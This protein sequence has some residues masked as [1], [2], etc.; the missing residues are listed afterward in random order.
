MKLAPSAFSLSVD[1]ATQKDE[2][3]YLLSPK[4]IVTLEVFYCSS[5]KGVNIVHNLLRNDCACHTAAEEA[6]GR[7]LRKLVT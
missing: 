2:T 5:T 6:T 1:I 4:F 3:S 7:L